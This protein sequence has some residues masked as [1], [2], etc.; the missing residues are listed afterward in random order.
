MYDIKRPA[1]DPMIRMLIKTTRTTATW[2]ATGCLVKLCE[3]KLC[4]LKLYET[5][6]V[7]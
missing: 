2:V 4:E 7:Q 5:T 3:T 6:G 1:Q